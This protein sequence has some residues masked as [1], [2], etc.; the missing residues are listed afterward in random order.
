M[1]DHTLFYQNKLQ[2]PKLISLL[3]DRFHRHTFT[4]PCHFTA[5]YERILYPFIYI[6]V[7][8]LNKTI[9]TQ[10]LQ[11]RNTC[12]TP[13]S[14]DQSRYRWLYGYKMNVHEDP[15]GHCTFSAVVFLKSSWHL[16]R[17][18]TNCSS[19]SCAKT[20]A[21]ERSF[22]RWVERWLRQPAVCLDRLAA[23]ETLHLVVRC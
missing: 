20:I 17:I 10:L 5:L 23:S 15:Q 2:D 19:V 1:L 11:N 21:Y 8:L 18:T 9:K 3:M 13:C 4:L 6:P 14:T 22:G 7:F 12:C 16:P